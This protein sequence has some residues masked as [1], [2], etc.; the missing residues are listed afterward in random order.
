[1]SE[2]YTLYS[3]RLRV[4]NSVVQSR[5]HLQNFINHFFSLNWIRLMARQPRQRFS[6]FEKKI[7]CDIRNF[8]KVAR[9]GNFTEQRD[10][11]LSYPS[12]DN[13]ERVLCLTWSLSIVEFCLPLWQSSHQH[14]TKTVIILT[15]KPVFGI[16]S[17]AINVLTPT[18]CPK[19]QSYLSRGT[20]ES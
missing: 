11:S 6:F 13:I 9:V 1:M 4:D 20:K 17:T 5:G 10:V 2:V 18:L 14:L 16:E 3:G 15:E 19:H 8:L 12:V 7:K